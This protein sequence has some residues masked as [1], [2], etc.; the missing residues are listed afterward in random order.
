MLHARD[1]CQRPLY[2]CASTGYDAAAGRGYHDLCHLGF[3]ATSCLSLVQYT[4]RYGAGGDYG[5]GSRGY[6]GA[7]SSLWLR[8]AHQRQYCVLPLCVA[9]YL[10][11][12]TAYPE[13]EAYHTS[14]HSDRAES[15]STSSG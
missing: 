13:P 10:N 8:T 4:L 11:C 7:C 15:T 12:F 1:R 9:A 2:L 14:Q 5:R 3:A 6:A